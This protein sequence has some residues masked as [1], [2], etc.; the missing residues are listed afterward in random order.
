MLKVSDLRA[1]S[2]EVKEAIAGINSTYMAVTKENLMKFMQEHK[3]ES[4]IL[5]LSLIP[6]HRLTGDPDSAKWNNLVGFYFLEKTDYSQYDAEGYLSIFE[7]TQEVARL[8]VNKLLEDKADNAGLFCGF[9]A[10][11]DEDS[12]GVDPIVALNGCNGYYVELAF[13]SNV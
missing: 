4:N 10:Y 6:S 2:T 12:I 5:M 13:K 1:Y 3:K 8:F 9:L 11:L 7:R